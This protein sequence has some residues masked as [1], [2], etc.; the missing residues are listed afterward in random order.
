MYFTYLSVYFIQH[1]PQQLTHVLFL[2]LRGKGPLKHTTDVIYAAKMISES[3]SRMDV[4]ARQIANQVSSL[5]MIWWKFMLKISS[6]K[7]ITSKFSCTMFVLMLLAIC[8]TITPGHILEPNM[9]PVIEPGLDAY[10]E[11]SL[12]FVLSP[13]VLKLFFKSYCVILVQG[14][15]YLY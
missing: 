12:Y 14:V 3:G 5:Q 9:V 11:S 2:F 4:L 8:S 10:Q 13:L 15:G 6:V 1:E 7:L